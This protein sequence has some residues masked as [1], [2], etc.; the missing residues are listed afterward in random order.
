M[1]LERCLI[2]RALAT[3]TWCWYQIGAVQLSDP[4][5]FQE[6]DDGTNEGDPR[7]SW[8]R[9]LDISKSWPD[10]MHDLHIWQMS[11]EKEWFTSMGTGTPKLGFTEHDL[12][13]GLGLYLGGQKKKLENSVYPISLA[14]TISSGNRRRA[15]R[16]N[17]R[18][19]CMLNVFMFL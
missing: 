3:C 8:R 5:M 11:L 7:H 4:S 2:Y 6:L 13:K 9:A 17:E 12:V 1:K 15:T 16:M 10:T 14:A 18:T 19:E